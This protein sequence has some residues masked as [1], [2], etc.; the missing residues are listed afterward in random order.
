MVACFVV[1][2]EGPFAL[3]LLVEFIDLVLSDFA[4]FAELNLTFVIFYEQADDGRII[5]G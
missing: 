4:R 1:V 5:P 2:A 3:E